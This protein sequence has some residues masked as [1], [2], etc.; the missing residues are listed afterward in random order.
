MT[1]HTK[2]N[3]GQMNLSA[4]LQMTVTPL[5]DY[6]PAAELHGYRVEL[7][8]G[9]KVDGRSPATYVFAQETRC[10]CT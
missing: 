6:T 9:C 1:E 2:R 8:D 10:A 3:G 5:A 4:Y 7:S